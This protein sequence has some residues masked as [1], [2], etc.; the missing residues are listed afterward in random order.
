MSGGT[1]GPGKGEGERHGRVRCG[2]EQCGRERHGRERCGTS[3]AAWEGEARDMRAQ[4]GGEG[5]GARESPP[6][7]RGVTVPPVQ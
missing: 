2:R 7:E 6:T 4:C 1:C 3:G 5:K